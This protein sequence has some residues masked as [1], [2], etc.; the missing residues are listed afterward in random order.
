MNRVK[1]ETWTADALLELGRSYQAAAVFAAGAELEVF[2]ALDRKD[3]TA[4][5]L[6]RVLRCDCRGLSV[7]LDAL[8]ALELLDQQGGRYSLEAGVREF[9][10]RDGARS[11]LAMSQHQANCLRNWAQL[12]RVVKSGRPAR[13]VASVRGADGDAA[14]FIG[15]MD[16]ISGPVADRVIRAVRPLRFG[17][18]LDVGGAS[19]T[20]TMAFL[21]ACPE[22]RATLFDLP[23]V[24]PMARRRLAAARMDRRVRLVAGDYMT[25][26]LPRGADLAWVSAIVHQNS[27][28]ENRTMFAKVFRALEV[29]GRIAIRD[30]VMEPNRTRPIAGALFAINMLV[31]TPGGGTFTFDEIRE[32]LESA[33]FTRARLAV[34]DPGMNSIV[35]AEKMDGD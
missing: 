32:D 24:I 31:A 28:A 13:R 34:R 2:D 25:D 23:H 30:I 33:G 18:L 27:R 11:L 1:Q 19:G 12:A 5:E 14:S 29:G 21:R 26:P 22:G 15:A 17:R 4:L 20:W 7:L 9:L 16:N 3:R 10:T 8:T 6:A 35:V